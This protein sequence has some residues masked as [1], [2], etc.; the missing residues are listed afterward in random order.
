YLRRILYADFVNG[1]TPGFLVTVDFEYAERP[2]PFSDCRAGFDICTRYRCTRIAIRTHADKERLVRTYD[3]VYLD[4]QPERVPERP[5]E[6]P[7]GPAGLRLNE[8]GVQLVAADGNGRAD[9]MVTTG[10]ISG[11]YPLSFEG[12]WD[13]RSF[14]RFQV[15]PSFDLRDPQ[16]HLVDLDGDGVTDAIHAGTRLE[17][18]FYRPDKGWNETQVVDR[19]ALAGLQG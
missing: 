5:R 10:P 9:L 3:L 14:Q 1:G 16:C 8:P 19:S 6:R 18:F 15:A 17:C 13:E 2:D 7:A 4:E 11:Y 12:R